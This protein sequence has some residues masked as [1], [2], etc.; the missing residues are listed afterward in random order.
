MKTTNKQNNERWYNV[1]YHKE[2]WISQ[3]TAEPGRYVCYYRTRS[4][5][6]AIKKIKQEYQKKPGYYVGRNP[7][8]ILIADRACKIGS[9]AYSDIKYIDE[10]IDGIGVGY[11]G[12]PTEAEF[13]KAKEAEEQRQFEAEY[14]KMREN[15]RKYYEQ[16]DR[17]HEAFCR[18]QNKRIAE[19]YARQQTQTQI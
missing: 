6:R 13:K 17:E 5:S 3:R 7:D 10:Y 18:E 2:G 19:W 14:E 11:W 1:Y 4:L 8:I 12:V 15:A 16:K 9:W